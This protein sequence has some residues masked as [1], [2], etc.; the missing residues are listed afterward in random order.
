MKIPP[1]AGL[2]QKM[3]MIPHVRTAIDPDPEFPRALLDQDLNLFA[4]TGMEHGPFPAGPR[5][6]QDHM[7]RPLGINGSRDLAFATANFTPVFERDLGKKGEL[8]LHKTGY[9]T[10]L[11]WGNGILV[12]LD[13]IHLS[14]RTL[15]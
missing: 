2:H 3:Q 15:D 1:S 14:N 13:R 7:E 6:P 9:S 12:E 8:L 5:G 4:M 10:Y 11:V